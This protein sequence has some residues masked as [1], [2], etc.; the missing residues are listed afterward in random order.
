MVLAFQ[1]QECCNN[2]VLVGNNNQLLT[3]MHLSSLAVS[4]TNDQERPKPLFIL[5]GWRCFS[6]TKIRSKSSFSPFQDVKFSHDKEYPYE[7]LPLFYVC[8]SW[9]FL[10]SRFICDFLPFYFYLW[11]RVFIW[12]W[13]TFS[14]KFSWSAYSVT[15]FWRA[16]Y[17]FYK[18]SPLI[19]LTAWF[20]INSWIV[21]IIASY[22]SIQEIN[23]SSIV[24]FVINWVHHRLSYS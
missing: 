24:Y 5:C 1:P 22:L 13:K 20:L 2:Q 7:Y 12:D 11:D 15:C 6:R 23:I 14:M 16:H 8:F 9:V 19:P 18:Q 21:E 17:Y 3:Y 4:T 10:F